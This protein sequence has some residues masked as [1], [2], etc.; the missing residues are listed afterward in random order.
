MGSDT[1]NSPFKSPQAAR[2][3][4]DWTKS[5]PWTPCQPLD[6]PVAAS[7]TG[8][9]HKLS[10]MSPKPMP[11]MNVIGSPSSTQNPC[12][13]DSCASSP[14]RGGYALDAEEVAHRLL[15][16]NSEPDL[17]PVCNP[18]LSRASEWQALTP[19]C[20][21]PKLMQPAVPKFAIAIAGFPSPASFDSS[22]VSGTGEAQ[23][24]HEEELAKCAFCGGVDGLGWGAKY[25][26]YCWDKYKGQWPEEPVI[27]SGTGGP[28]AAHA[29]VDEPASIDTPKSPSPSPGTPLVSLSCDR[30]GNEQIIKN[31]PDL[32]CTQCQHWV[33]FSSGSVSSS[34]TT[35]PRPDRKRRLSSLPDR[36]TGKRKTL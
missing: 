36:D 23:A 32:W 12:G 5:S 27:S 33:V 34:M 9:M 25:C 26:M 7:L 1:T 2:T 21:K 19:E 13:T 8:R 30:C 4:W 35:P 16:I 6:S 14:S 31:G 29:Q 11:P 15:V 28:Q 20:P 24:T 18:P 10:L 3:A 17:P 22:V